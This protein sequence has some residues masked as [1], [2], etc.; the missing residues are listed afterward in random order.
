MLRPGRLTKADKRASF[1]K[2]RHTG[3]DG[4]KDRRISLSHAISFNRHETG[5]SS[6]RENPLQLL[7][8]DRFRPTSTCCPLTNRTQGSPE[9]SRLQATP[10]FGAVATATTPLILKEHVIRVERAL[11]RLEYVGSPATQDLANEIATM[12][13]AADDLFD[14]HAVPRERHDCRICIL[15][16]QIAPVS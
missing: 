1:N 15:A 4:G 9:T 16:P 2:G 14:R 5:D 7:F 6:G 13:Q 8:A 11:P 3:L 10:E 12:A